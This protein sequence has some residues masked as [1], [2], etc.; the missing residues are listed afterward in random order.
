MYEN[1]SAI[2]DASKF[3]EMH[4]ARKSIYQVEEVSDNGLPLEWITKSHDWVNSRLDYER[5]FGVGTETEQYEWFDFLL[6]IARDKRVGG[7]Q[8]LSK[9]M[10]IK[11]AAK[12]QNLFATAYFEGHAD[13]NVNGSFYATKRAK[14]KTEK[15]I[16]N[17]VRK[18]ADG[19]RLIGATTREKVAKEG[20]LHMGQ[21]KDDAS[22][23]IGK[24][25]GRS[26]GTVK[27]YLTE[28]YPGQEWET[29]NQ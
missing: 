19:R 17:K 13:G 6:R 15:S 4:Y 23:A 22:Y 8:S 14:L 9:C 7:T 11:W 20:K 5:D 29:T 10:L 3:V 25:I 16:F 27:R 18:A 1:K 2:D 24:I 26:S 28:L 12:S 21:S